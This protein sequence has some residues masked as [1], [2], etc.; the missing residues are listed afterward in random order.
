M[1]QSGSL[2]TEESKRFYATTSLRSIS[3]IG[4]TGKRSEELLQLMPVAETGN[5][6]LRQAVEYADEE[7]DLKL[8]SARDRSCSYIL[9]LLQQAWGCPTSTLA[10]LLL[11]RFRIS[12][13]LLSLRTNAPLDCVDDTHQIT[14]CFCQCSDYMDLLWLLY[15]VRQFHRRISG[16]KRLQYRVHSNEF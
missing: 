6:L 4:G 13:C 10:S 15:L 3:A 16:R 5:A 14:I 11:E 9:R 1:L 2:K 7:S 12:C 8:L